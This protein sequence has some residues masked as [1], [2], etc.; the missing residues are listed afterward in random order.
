[1]VA[2][3]L[4][5]GQ[6]PQVRWDLFSTQASKAIALEGGRRY[7]IASV[8]FVYDERYYGTQRLDV[9]V[10][11]SDKE[12]PPT[13]SDIVP[14]ASL[15]PYAA[16]NCTQIDNCYGCAAASN[17]AWCN[18]TC[19]DASS[20]TCD[21]PVVDYERCP[22]C[23]E[24]TS[25]S[26]CAR[27]S[28]C[29]WVS[30]FC[31]RQT[32]S[33]SPIREVK[34]CPAEC[35]EL[36]SCSTCV[37][38]GRCGWC[39]SSQRCFD[40]NGYQ[41][42]YA[43]GD[44]RAWSTASFHCP[45]CASHNTCASCIKDFECGWLASEEDPAK[46]TCTD[47]DFAGPTNSSGAAVPPSQTQWHYSR[48]PEV[49]ECLL[50]YDNCSPDA[51]C[52]DKS[53]DF[54][55]SFEC[56]CR[57]GYSGSGTEC[58][59]VCEGCR[60]SC[61]APGQCRCEPGWTG[62]TCAQCTYT[63][64]SSTA[65]GWQHMC[66]ANAACVP[67]AYE[68]APMNFIFATYLA[69]PGYNSSA[70]L[71]C[72]CGTGYKGDA[73]D[74][75]VASCDEHGC[76]YGTCEAPG[77][78][79]CRPGFAGR[80]CTEC[81]EG[82]RDAC[83]P[84]AMCTM[85]PLA[86]TFPDSLGPECTCRAGYTGDGSLCQPVCNSACVRGEC[87][88]PDT[89]EC[90][91]GWQGSTCAECDPAQ[92]PCGAHASCTPNAD[93]AFDCSCDVGYS[94][95]PIV[96]CFPTCEPACIHGLCDEPDVC[97]CAA[98]WTGN[99]CDSCI[100]AAEVCPAHA[101]C[102]AS[103]AAFQCA[104]D[105]GYTSSLD[106]RG[107]LQACRPACPSGCDMGACVA[108][109]VC[110]CEPGW[111]NHLFAN[112]TEC[113]SGAELRNATADPDGVP[114]GCAT[115]GRCQGFGTNGTHPYAC[116][117][118]DGHV[119]T[120]RVPRAGEESIADYLARTQ[121]R[122]LSGRVN[123]SELPPPGCQPVCSDACI[124]GSCE[125]PETC[126]C[127][128]G[129]GGPLCTLCPADNVCAARGSECHKVTQSRLSALLEGAIIVGNTFQHNRTLSGHFDDAYICQC[130]PGYTG[131]GMV[132]EA[133][134]PQG[135]VH[136]TCTTPGVC[137]CDISKVLPGQAAWTGLNCTECV[138][139]AHPC[140]ANSTCSSRQGLLHCECDYGEDDEGLVISGFPRGLPSL[141]IRP[142]LEPTLPCL[143][144]LNPPPP[145]FFSLPPT[146]RL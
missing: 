57:P 137:E 8:S 51:E 114:A 146:F 118:V 28:R 129:W 82:N 108:P 128:R 102:L 142:I 109:G 64:N 59:P 127:D 119:G 15:R 131:N 13:D 24:K 135:C 113:V 40:F 122:S 83:S 85:V 37:G 43:H 91:A 19:S 70:P 65:E 50:D 61:I 16:D 75:C 130:L 21:A 2:Q 101:S 36:S 104:C 62:S 103:D 71:E 63:S 134:C 25:C 23:E 80:D 92:P 88:A 116:T 105:T 6:R 22:S 29:E 97:K 84:F 1:L 58:A 46:G 52:T 10:T 106:S 120:G 79:L 138:Q 87:T 27:T 141:V 11:L 53:G 17:C 32:S 9:A 55:S 124:H 39:S 139:G 93:G 60:G 126:V 77:T 115:Y 42:R 35:S 95:D 76:V 145:L 86:G 44:C 7:Y 4:S 20:S 99:A 12:G 67:T 132:C 125:A 38:T 107:V 112:C 90:P 33:V 34:S 18:G 14:A 45:A 89:C 123:S 73:I 140:H 3:E 69:D 144:K 41:T 66:G 31:R 117:C 5:S 143:T 48:C 98:G 56:Q 136:G 26:E 110:S 100:P 47:G 78:C 30:Y 94:G 74:G 96:G 133:Q 111:E 81:S 72:R 121:Y 54:G 49:N 68:G